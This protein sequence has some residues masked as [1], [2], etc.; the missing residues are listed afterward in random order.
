MAIKAEEL[1]DIEAMLADADAS[2]YATLRQKYPHLAWSRCDASD[3][4]QEPYRSFKSFDVHLF[5][6]SNHC[7]VVVNDP[8]AASG[9]ILAARSASQ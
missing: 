2:I 4:D 9:M 1:Q 8:A 5:D 3:V 6:V 7:P